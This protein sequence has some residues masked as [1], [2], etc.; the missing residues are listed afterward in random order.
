MS[1]LQVQAELKLK[2]NLS[3]PAGTALDSLGKTAAKTGTAVDSIGKGQGMQRT[4]KDAADAARSMDTVNRTAQ[5]A[6]R[7]MDATARN[8]RQVKDAIPWS[9]SSPQSPRYCK[10]SLHGWPPAKVLCCRVCLP[11]FHLLTA[12]QTL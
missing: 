9:R 6:S 7:S 3:R 1:D 11:P 10:R 8:T 4:A 2:D 5:D 12:L